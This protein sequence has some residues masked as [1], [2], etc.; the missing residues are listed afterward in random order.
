MDHR[1]LAS[2]ALLEGLAQLGLR[3]GLRGRLQDMRQNA[4]PIL[5]SHGVDLVLSGHSHSYERSFF[6]D[7]HYGNSSSFDPATMLVDGGD[8]RID[9]NGAYQKNS[10]GAVY[11]VAG[12]SGETSGGTLDHVVMYLSL[13]QL[14]SVVLDFTGNQLD[15]TFIDEVGVIHDYL[16]ITKGPPGTITGTVTDSASGF[17]IAGATVSYIGGSTTTDP[18]G[19]YSLTDVSVGEHVVTVVAGGYGSLSQS[20]TVTAGGTAILNF[21]LSP[22]G[23]ITG[24]VTDSSNGIPIAGATITYNGGATTTDSNGNYTVTSIASGTQT[25][26]AAANGYTPSSQIVTV[27]AG[28]TATANFALVPEPSSIGGVVYDS[29]T[30]TQIAGATV[31]YVGG[32]TAT[33]S[34][35]RYDFPNVDPGPYTV[36]ASAPGYVTAS[37]EV[38][39][40]PV[41]EATADF[42]LISTGGTSPTRIKDITFE[43]GSLIDVTNGVDRII[44]TVDLETAAPLKEVFSVHVPNV[45]SSYFEETFTP[46]DDAYVSFYIRLNA[47]PASTPRI[48]LLSNAGTTVGNIVLKTDGTLRLRHGHPATTIGTSAVALIPGQLYRIG[49]HQKRGT[50]G[51]AVL[52]AFLAAND[53]PFG[54][55]FAAT[56]AGTWTTAADRYRAGATTTAVDIV[57]DDIKLDGGSMPLP[58]GGA[59]TAPIMSLLPPSLTFSDQ[60]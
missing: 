48:A 11:I 36:T 15:S 13:A 49:M 31:S 56:N 51:N 1:L 35:G 18:N 27:P 28:G 12:S 20:A 50:G 21:A 17:G 44:G 26:S 25:L 3:V 34:L 29:V 4:L 19:D 22:P 45:S 23:T 24:Q 59:G 8:G 14:G 42:P 2:P 39:V 38:I 9:G 40:P 54:P 5:E 46:T 58:S 53:D 47:L 7:G 52:E 37:K 30:G 33:D 55:P 6:I 16:T 60:K 57:F 41:G 32:S 10:P 43:S